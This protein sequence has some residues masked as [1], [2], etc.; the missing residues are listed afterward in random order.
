MKV[1]WLGKKNLDIL[2]FPVQAALIFAAGKPN[3]QL[4]PPNN[5]NRIDVMLSIFNFGGFQG[6]GSDVLPEELSKFASSILPSSRAISGALTSK[7]SQFLAPPRNYGDDS[8]PFSRNNMDFIIQNAY[9]AYVS[10]GKP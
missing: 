4:N 5:M 1:S 10:Q 3:C 9:K 8:K 6:G 7:I 2:G